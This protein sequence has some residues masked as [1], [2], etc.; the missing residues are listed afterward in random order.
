MATFNKE[1]LIKWNDLSTSLQ[2]I[3]MRKITWDMLHPDLQAW[4]LDKE[5]RIIELEH[6]RKNKAD[7]MLDDH[8]NRIGDCES[9]ISKLWNKLGDAEDRMTDIATN[10][11]GA[12]K[13][14]ILEW[15]FSPDTTG[16]IN[17]HVSQFDGNITAAFNMKPGFSSGIIELKTTIV[18]NIVFTHNISS[19][20]HVPI[21]PFHQNA[22]D[23]NNHRHFG[24]GTGGD[25]ILSGN[26]EFY[27]NTLALFDPFPC[28]KG[29]WPPGFPGTVFCPCFPY[30]SFE[31]KTPNN[32]ISIQISGFSHYNSLDAMQ[33]KSFDVNKLYNTSDGGYFYSLPDPKDILTHIIVA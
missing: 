33:F 25:V 1:D 19:F 22:G 9:E 15:W 27:W 13:Y 23:I 16:I 17:P 24:V 29:A 28:N 4:L 10:A 8:E 5:K 14:K 26:T 2:D 11:I 30:G 3:I 7:P 20:I 21:G 12:G 31:P 6:W 18:F 32:L